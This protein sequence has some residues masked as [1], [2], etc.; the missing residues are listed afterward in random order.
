MTMQRQR[1][2]VPVAL[3]VVVA[4][5]VV[6]V[7]VVVATSTARGEENVVEGLPEVRDEPTG[8]ETTSDPGV[9]TAG[10]T[11]PPP[12]GKRR[13]S[14]GQQTPPASEPSP[15]D[16]RPPEIRVPR[17]RVGRQSPAP[18]A[19]P[20]P[21]APETRP[22][23]GRQEAPPAAETRPARVGRAD[24]PAPTPKLP[25]P[26]PAPAEPPQPPKRAG[27]SPSLPAPVPTPEPSPAPK[28]T[29]RVEL[30]DIEYRGNV[31]LDRDQVDLFYEIA[32]KQFEALLPKLESCGI[33]DIRYHVNVDCTTRSEYWQQFRGVY[34][35]LTN[36]GKIYKDWSNG[37]VGERL[38]G[39]P[40]PIGKTHPEQWQV[41]YKVL[42]RF[43]PNPGGGALCPYKGLME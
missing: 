4:A 24:L 23:A 37:C 31:R 1:S 40:M 21:P 3:A 39:E 6:G 41:S 14:R 43:K 34:M 8:G 32:S 26:A 28:P 29:K 33:E 5:L 35:Y 11:T 38:V 9:S 10:T 12:T 17:P 13:R 2:Y 42:R 25:G 16:T 22:P 30:I 15:S 7:S 27:R 18:V 36:D 19:E 20:Q